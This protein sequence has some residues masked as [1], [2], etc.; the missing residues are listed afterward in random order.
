MS[1]KEVRSLIVYVPQEAYLFNFSIKENIR[2]GDLKA[3]EDEIVI[4]AKIANAHEFILELDK[5]MIQFVEKKDVNYRRDKGRE[6][7]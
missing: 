7:L 2:L 3:T 4:A 5:N 6:L 1:N